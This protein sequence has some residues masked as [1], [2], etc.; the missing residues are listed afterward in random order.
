MIPIINSISSRGTLALAAKIVEPESGRVL[1][2]YTTE[3]GMQFYTPAA[4]L[5]YL[6]GMASSHMGGITAF[7]SK[8]NIFRIRLIIRIFRLPCCC[9]ERLTGKPRST[10]LK[11]YPKQNKLFN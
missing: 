10:D 4:N 6:K 11:H 8:C 9:R 2:A 7:V 5:D 3:P 1:K